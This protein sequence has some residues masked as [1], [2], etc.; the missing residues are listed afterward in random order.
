MR[1][2]RILLVDVSNVT[3]DT[4]V[5]MLEY[6]IGLLYVG[7]ALKDAYGD[8]IDLR[9]ESY[10][11][12][13]GGMARLEALLSAW[14]PDLLGL[15]SLTMGRGPLHE[16]ARLA[17][18]RYGVGVAVAGGP[19]ASDNPH[20]VLANE[21]FDGAVVGEGERTA[22][23]LVGRLLAGESLDGIPGLARRVDGGVALQPRAVIEALDELPIP[24]YALIDFLGI[25]RGHV[26][27]S[28]RRNVKHANLFTS[29]GCPYR[30]LY[31]HQVFGKRMRAH[32]AERVLEEVK[33]LHDGWGITHFQIIDDI[34]NLDRDRAMTFYDLVVREGLKLVISFPNG[35]RG[36][37]V[38]DEMVD[39][40]WDAGVR[41]ISYA[42]ETGSPRIQKLIQKNMNLDRI[43]RAIERSTAKGIVCKGYFMLGFPTE[44]EEEALQTI[45][46]ANDSDLVLA[47]FFTVVYFPGTPLYKLAASLRDMSGYR[48][49]LEDDYVRTREGPYEFSRDRLDEIKRQGIR[50]FFFSP[51][52]VDLAFRVLPNFFPRRDIDASFLVN[53][54]SSELREE[55][56][57]PQVA[58]RLHR[59][60]LVADRFS[61]HAG[62]F[63]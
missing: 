26:D 53:V 51:K 22:V 50:D 40:M 6:P 5:D 32:S 62:F 59:Y 9:I 27:F 21:A 8:R 12:K 61:R 48:L 10:E 31:C 14:R 58:A 46:F 35:L 41:Y 34:F 52:R 20:D 47:M 13:A 19:H 37:R 39:A 28:F 54:I 57:D 30:C 56:L 16:I 29:R 7:T 45:Q 3:L 44:T 4:T 17:K 63:V 18:Q 23:E 25:N 11:H 24:D 55:D 2:L 1:P 43:R 33:R 42:I 36:D 15:R 60:F 49:G 38:D